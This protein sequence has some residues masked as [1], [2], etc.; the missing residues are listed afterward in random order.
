LQ[1]AQLPYAAHYWAYQA[2][3]SSTWIAGCCSGP[4]GQVA[5]YYAYS[6]MQFMRTTVLRLAF[7]N[8]A[9]RDASLPQQAEGIAVISKI[10]H[11]RLAQVTAAQAVDESQWRANGPT[12]PL[13]AAR[14]DIEQADADTNRVA[15]TLAYIRAWQRLVDVDPPIGLIIPIG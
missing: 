4:G 9:L 7:G 12:L 8:K 11:E 14:H 10:A 6:V 2:W 1:S 5:P 13:W 15:A 3:I